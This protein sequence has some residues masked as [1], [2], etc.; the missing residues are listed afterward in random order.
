MEL[1]QLCILLAQRLATVL[2]EMDDV[3][4]LKREHNDSSPNDFLFGCCTASNGL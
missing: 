1:K 2:S 3:S 4:P